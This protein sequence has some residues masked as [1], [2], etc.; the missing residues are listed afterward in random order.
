MPINAFMSKL[1][2]VTLSH[3]MISPFMRRHSMVKSGG[4]YNVCFSLHDNSK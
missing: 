2:N 4:D 3:G 1:L